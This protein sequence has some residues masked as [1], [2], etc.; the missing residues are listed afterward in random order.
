MTNSELYERV[1]WMVTQSEN[2]KYQDVSL[3]QALKVIYQN[4]LRVELMYQNAPLKLFAYIFRKGA[5]VFFRIVFGLFMNRKARIK[6]AKNVSQ[7]TRIIFINDHPGHVERM[8]LSILDGFDKDKVHILTRSSVLYANLKGEF[9]VISDLSRILYFLDWRNLKQG[10]KFHR[11]LKQSVNGKGVFFSFQFFVS[12]FEILQAV[13]FYNQLLPSENV[14]ALVTMSDRHLHE[15]V[16]SLVAQQKGLKTYTNQHGDFADLPLYTPIASD[17]MF[18]WG[19][20]T[21]QFLIE[22][23]MSSEQIIISGNP[24]FDR[25]YSWYHPNIE[26]LREKRMSQWGLC[27]EKLTITFLS[28]GISPI[29]EYT[30]SKL[31]EL[32]HC[33]CQVCN[34]DINPIVK[35]HPSVD[36]DNQSTYQTWLRD[37]NSAFKVHYFQNQDLF[38]IFCFTDIAVNSISTAGLDAIGFGIPTVSL[39][40]VDGVDINKHTTFGESTIECRSQK[41]FREIIDDLINEPASLRIEKQRTEM[42]SRLYFENAQG[43]LASDFLKNYLLKV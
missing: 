10:V 3:G 18:V 38:D 39:N 36:N 4:H 30:E 43:I 13:D 8:M 24:K 7:H 23:G 15:Y 16:A 25:V 21:R 42:E 20:K 19:K 22:S 2:I 33:F 40:I 34:Y 14:V 35:L 26:T 6:D 11:L 12:V 41:E 5:S 27:A 1:E 9:P 28:T 29:A 37:I 31:Y 17:A 32:F